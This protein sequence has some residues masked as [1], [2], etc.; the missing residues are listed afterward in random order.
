MDRI[1]NHIQACAEYAGI[2]VKELLTVRTMQ[3]VHSRY[4]IA[5][6]GIRLYNLDKR[7]IA[8]ALGYRCERNVVTTA[9]G[10]IESELKIR[11]MSTITKLNFLLCK[12]LNTTAE[13]TGGNFYLFISSKKLS[14]YSLSE[15][16]NMAKINGRD[17][18]TDTIDSKLHYSDTSKLMKMGKSLTKKAGCHTSH[19][20]HGTRSFLFTS[21]IQ[22]ANREALRYEFATEKEKLQLFFSLAKAAEWGRKCAYENKMR[23]KQI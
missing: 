8:S 14:K 18:T 9:C 6:I 22:W 19:T 5:W 13:K 12:E 21:D 16:V 3:N 20:Q 11:R 7:D 23:N 10:I 1:H 2:T 15:R 4:I 17:L